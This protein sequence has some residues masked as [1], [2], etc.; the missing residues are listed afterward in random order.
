MKALIDADIVAYSCAA[1]NDPWGWDACRKDI[2]ELMRRILETTGADTYEAFISGA[3]NFRYGI[4]PDYRRIAKERLIH[5]IEQMQ[6]HIS[7]PNFTPV[8]LMDMRQMT[9]SALLQLH[10][11][12]ESLLFAPST[13]I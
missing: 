3:D 10:W 8:S 6:M 9:H 5:N 4:N 12:M 11:E 13:K 2:D 1:Y 7:L